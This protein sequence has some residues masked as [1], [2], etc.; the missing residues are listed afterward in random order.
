VQPPPSQASAQAAAV[1]YGEHWY[2]QSH[3]L[4]TYAPWLG[5]PGF[6]A[7]EALV[8]GSTLVD[9]YRLYEL[10]QL[11]EQVAK[12]GAGE[13]LEL[14][15]WRGGSGALV[16]KRARML[17]VDAPVWLCD[18]F[19]GVVKTSEADP[20]YDGGEHADAD[21]TDVRRLVK[22]MGLDGVEI[23]RGIFPDATGVR[24]AD[25]TFRF[26]HFDLDVY[27]STRDAFAWVWPRLVP[28]GIAV[29]DDYG[30]ESCAGVTR[31]VDEQRSQPGR[32][33][34]HNLNG[35]AVMIKAGG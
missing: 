13:F 6:L 24:I 23:L 30:F 10:W 1:R 32:T 34:L 17:G 5:D 29:F 3:P 20:S 9:R 22:D 33:V 19:Q 35:H 27:D 25:R 31:F 28:G 15:V 21:E 26:C 18:T 11:V 16:A 2:S 8:A 14:G 7:V 12:L 4:A